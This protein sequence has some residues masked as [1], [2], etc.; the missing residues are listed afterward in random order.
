M[1]RAVTATE[2]SLGRLVADVLEVTEATEMRDI[3]QEVAGLVPDVEL[4]NALGEALV[5]YVRVRATQPA[6]KARQTIAKSSRWQDA[7][8]AYLSYMKSFVGIP[9]VGQ[10]RRADVTYDEQKAIAALRR[11]QAAALLKETQREYMIVKAME[12][13]D[14]KQVGDLDE[15]VVLEILRWEP[16]H[17]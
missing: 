17:E 15:S 10:K 3:A 4:R 9:G 8:A 16:D 5:D 6:H 7:S 11:S 12:Q 1:T 2:F 13:A 14:V